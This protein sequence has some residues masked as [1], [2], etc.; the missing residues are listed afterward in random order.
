ML[1][2]LHVLRPFVSSPFP[3]I[4]LLVT[5]VLGGSGL[6]KLAVVYQ[7]FDSDVGA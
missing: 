2:L 4:L 7:E 5:R 3:V 1:L 6:S